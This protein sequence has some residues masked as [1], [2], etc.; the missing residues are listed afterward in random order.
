M[1]ILFGLYEL[2]RS[3]GVLAIAGLILFDIALGICEALKRGEF[4]WGKLWDFLRT[5]ILPDF[6]GYLALQ[7]ALTLLPEL[8]EILDGLLPAGFTAL[9]FAAIVGKLGASILAHALYLWGA[10]FGNDR[11]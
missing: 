8:G 10:L 9:L 7:V 5:M 11:T 3:W 6:L 4:E 1:D 2:L